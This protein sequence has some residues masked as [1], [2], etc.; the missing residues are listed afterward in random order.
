MVWCN[1]QLNVSFWGGNDAREHHRGGDT[2][3]RREGEFFLGYEEVYRGYGD[4]QRDGGRSRV[5]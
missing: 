3:G 1:R 4:S 5:R 2:S